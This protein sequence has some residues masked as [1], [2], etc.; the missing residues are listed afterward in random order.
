MPP[1]FVSPLKDIAAAE[2]T[3]VTFEGCVG[4]KPEP[5]IRWFRDGR[6]LTGG[7]DFEIAY[8]EGRVR[9]SIPEAFPEDSGK[10]TCT[11]QNKAGQSSSTAELV[12]KGNCGFFFLSSVSARRLV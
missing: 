10:Y 9:L 4:G 11:A 1:E 8:R 7:A 5:T 12:V 2:G 3:R 6:P